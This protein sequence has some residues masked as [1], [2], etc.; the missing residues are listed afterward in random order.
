MLRA[1]TE[2]DLPM[3]AALQDRVMQHL[4]GVGQAHFIVPRD[5]DYF[6][7]HLNPPHAAYGIV[8]GD[9]LS[10]QALYHCPAAFK[11]L[12]TG[13]GYIPGLRDGARVS[14]LQGALV[15]PAAQRQG[16]MRKLVKH[17]LDWCR[18]HKMA[19][20]LARVEVSHVASRSALEQQG[21]HITGTVIDAR[22]DVSVHVLIKHLEHPEQV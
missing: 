3:M 18:Q 6:R 12:H 5:A 22:D 16:F 19:H 8:S 2:H 9:T 21:L 13:L 17:W 7:N 15:D 1:L 4:R 20:V 14:I 11:V 10:A